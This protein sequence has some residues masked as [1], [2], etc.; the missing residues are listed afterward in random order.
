MSEAPAIVDDTPR[1]IARGVLYGVLAVAAAAVVSFVYEKVALH[2]GHVPQP[3]PFFLNFGKMGMTG[4]AAAIAAA[5]VL[6]PVLEELV[7]RK[8]LLGYMARHMNAAVAVVISSAVFAAAHRAPDAFAAVFAASIFFS[9]SY[10]KNS[11]LLSSTTSH[12]FFNIASITYFL[13]FGI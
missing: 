12:L 8:L 10:L 11:S 4:K 13:V 5:V 9:L 6:S 1:A 7:F 2:F 3:Q